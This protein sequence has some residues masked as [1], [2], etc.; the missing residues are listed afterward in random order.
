MTNTNTITKV[1]NFEGYYFH[2]SVCGREIM[3]AYRINGGKEIFGKECVKTSAYGNTKKDIAI[4][5]QRMKKLDRLKKGILAGY[6]KM[7]ADFGEK[8][9]GMILRGLLY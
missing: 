6:D 3:H 4:A 5:D 2:C 9:D 8:T 1:A 7:V